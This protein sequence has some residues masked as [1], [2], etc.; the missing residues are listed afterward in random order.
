MIDTGAAVSM[1]N[2]CA[3]DRL[4]FKITGKRTQK[5]F[6]AGN[7]QLPL[8]DSLVEVKI[9]VAKCGWIT[10]KDVVVC[11][12]QRKVNM[13]LM[14]GPD[15]YRMGTIL[16]YN[17]G[18]V[19]ITKGDKA[20]T[21]LKMPTVR[22]L[23]AQDVA[24]ADFDNEN[25]EHI[26]C[27]HMFQNMVSMI[28]SKATVK[29]NNLQNDKDN[30][31]S[32]E[33]TNHIAHVS[34]LSP[35]QVGK[36]NDRVLTSIL[37]SKFSNKKLK[38]EDFESVMDK[39]EAD[40][41]VCSFESE[42]GDEC[43]RLSELCR[44]CQQ[45]VDET[46]VEFRR[47]FGD[48]PAINSIPGVD[49]K[50]ILL[51]YIERIRQR[52]RETLSHN[53]CTID[54]KFSNKHPVVA[55]AVRKLIQKHK[56]VFAGD[57]GCL[58][59]EYTVKATIR[60][61]TKSI[62]RP[63]H[64]PLTG[65][66]LLSVLK[67]MSE[68]A[69]SGVIRSCSELGIE[70]KN[71][72]MI[73]PV[74]KKTEDGEKIKILSAVRIVN[75]CRELN[76]KT[77]F[78]GT[79]TD[80]LVKALDFAL[81]ASESGFNMKA[82][83]ANA[84]FVIPIDETLWPYFCINIPYLGRYCFVRI[85]QGW[86]PA[87][88]IC[89]DTLTRLF[90]AICRFF[91][92]YMDDIMLATPQCPKMYLKTLNEFFTICKNN[93]LRIKGKKCSF[94]LTEFCYLGNR[95]KNGK[96]TA[97]PHYVMKLKATKWT[98]IIT[99][100][101]MRSYTMSVRFLAKFFRRSTEVLNALCEASKGAKNEKIVWTDSLKC[102][103][104]KSKRALDELSTLH[105]FDPDLPTVIYVDTS[106][107][108]TGGFLYQL[109][110]SE[111]R[112]ISF[113]SRTRNDKERKFPLSAC[114]LEMQGLKSLIYAFQ[115]NL[116]QARNTVTV[117]TDSRGVVKIFE[118]FRKGQLPSNDTVL[119]NALYCILSTVDCHVQHASATNTSI[120]F[121]DNM[122]RLNLFI[123][124]DPCVG[125]PKC[126]ICAAADPDSTEAKVI[127]AIH[128]IENHSKQ[129]N[130]I[131]KPLEQDHIGFP[132][133]QETFG[134]YDMK[135]YESISNITPQS[136][137]YT[138]R[139][140]LDDKTKLASMQKEDKIL[141]QLR[142]G[143]ENNVV[144]F[145]KK[146]RRLLT[147]LEGRNAKLE[148]GV[149]V[150]DRVIDG[151][152]HRVVPLPE[153]GA[154]IAISATH[155]TVGHTSQTQLYKQVQR[156]FDFAKMKEKVERFSN[157]CVKCVLHRGG[158]G[159]QKDKQ[160]SVPIP[161]RFYET[162]LVDEVTRTFRGE[163]IKLFVAMET[164]SNFMMVVNY[165][166]PMSASLFAQI[167]CQIK[168]ALCPHSMDA[169]VVTVRADKAAWHTSPT[170]LETLKMLNIEMMFHHST[171]NSKN[172][173][174][175]LD[176]RIRIFSQYLVQL[177][178]STPYNVATCCHL[179]AAKSNTSVTSTGRT[180]A[181]LFTG[182]GWRNGENL[183]IDVKQLIESIRQRRQAKRLYEE[184]RR[185][186][187][188][189]KRQGE[190]IPYKD[191]DLNSPYMNLP[192]LFE[193]Q[194]GDTVVLKEDYDK[195]EPRY[196]YVVEKLNFG[197]KE[198]YVRRDSGLDKD[199][200]EAKW[201]SFDLIH[202]FFS[203]NQNSYITDFGNLQCSSNEKEPENMMQ[204]Y[205]DVMDHIGIIYIEDI[206]QDQLLHVH[207]DYISTDPVSEIDLPLAIQVVV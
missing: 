39:H 158:G 23:A 92:K 55:S 50:I 4:N 52:Q 13:V 20:G 147:Y 53:E 162:I 124:P 12:G 122:S 144:S 32:D 108:A 135:P 37:V 188:N 164:L 63:G 34:I 89:Q 156:H 202:K 187:K 90:F 182:R 140:L 125:E 80:N 56:K 30:N 171:T 128:E 104:E 45:C 98:D 17:L 195:N 184:R 101:N 146:K 114:H 103:F 70:P 105:G 160:K 58:G 179:A 93:G 143:L 194:I 126:S 27:S 113:F 60:N 119:N 36:I 88:Q 145:D 10:L 186:L 148:D 154:M 112:L 51:Q 155:N 96:L 181:E 205:D 118:R 161:N 83:V 21:K 123:N 167:M 200:P 175:E 65:D 59:P 139:T 99:V 120:Q 6:G 189:Y 174:P 14:G 198:V 127:Y 191:D 8:G 94:G 136:T 73:L 43:M 157:W 180:P 69:A 1:I 185:A 31:E 203:K 192:G 177:V 40:R 46:K 172:I 201:I 206:D 47:K 197:K 91:E 15:I 62:R 29:D 138:L 3:L 74:Q 102:S 22:H 49:N 11:K 19:E 71:E 106:K 42:N 25:S 152:V 142:K 81:K 86:A 107:I 163:N 141:F 129:I 76:S 183:Q 9:N 61:S 28:S 178:E 207:P 82:D 77:E 176:S 84:Y 87:A 38:F 199:L 75:D 153:E 137:K 173:I 67:T 5:Y 134:K 68:L 72:L 78:T 165:Q 35:A 133:D 121:A 110:E 66:K 111:P 41:S 48:L 150:V 79:Q 166:G 190:L 97:S 100:T 26:P 16:N 196:E 18:Q 64:N 117:V 149:V 130:S 7:E 193:L 57:I 109:H 204:F 132:K 116:S 24:F 131:F 33:P 170:L 151:V 169:T 115:P 54:E 85:V 44:G 95:V 168:V 159:F 2:E